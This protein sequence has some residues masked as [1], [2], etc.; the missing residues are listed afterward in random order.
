VPDL[1]GEGWIRGDQ[2]A[3]GRAGDH[4]VPVE[5]KHSDVSQG[6]RMAAS[7]SGPEGLRSIL[8]QRDAVSGADAHQVIDGG[9]LTEE[10]HGHDGLGQPI[11]PRATAEEVREEI[12]IDVP[13]GTVGI[14]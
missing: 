10:V 5:R 6:A 3:S 7:I 12:G 2:H 9:R 8:D 14:N 1:G 4:L 13:G 11:V